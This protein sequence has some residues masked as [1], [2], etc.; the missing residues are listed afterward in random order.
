MKW[1]IWVEPNQIF[2][3]NYPDGWS[4]ADVERAANNRYGGKV[5][6]VHPAPVGA[7]PRAPRSSGG[8]SASEPGG[9]GGVLL[10]I[11]GAIAVGAFAG[12][13]DDTKRPSTPPESLSQPQS[14]VDPVPA[15]R[16]EATPAPYAF[17]QR[18]LPPRPD[19]VVPAEQGFDIRDQRRNGR[20]R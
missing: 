6:G 4:H 20:D 13:G 3:E 12:G 19:V 17:E 10:L 14:L 5:T 18:G 16:W 11:I 15:D 1:S 9:C 8:G 7:E 2:E